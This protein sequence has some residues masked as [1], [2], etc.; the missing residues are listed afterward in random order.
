MREAARIII[1]VGQ[2]PQWAT[3]FNL[4]TG[5]KRV[6]PEIFVRNT[7]L[8]EEFSNTRLMIPRYRIMKCAG[9]VLVHK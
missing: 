7:V 3:V 9:A 1:R 5:E 2:H 4:R 8:H 6:P